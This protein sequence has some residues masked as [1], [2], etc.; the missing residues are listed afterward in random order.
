MR[1]AKGVPLIRV[2]DLLLQLPRPAQHIGVDRRWRRRFQSRAAGREITEV[3][4]EKTQRVADLP[5]GV[6]RGRQ[7]LKIH[8]DVVLVGQ[9][10]DPPPAEIRSETRKKILHL[11]RVADALGHLQAGSVHHEPVREHGGE[12]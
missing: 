6:A 10:A 3:A 4:Q 1:L 8:L 11:D 7:G 9:R 2:L 5:V 12:G